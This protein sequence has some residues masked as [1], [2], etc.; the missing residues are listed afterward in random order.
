MWMSKGADRDRVDVL[1][2]FEH[3][4][5]GGPAIRAE[6]KRRSFAGIS[7][8]NERLRFAVTLRRE[9]RACAPKTL[10]VRRWQA[11]Q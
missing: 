3:V 2:I 7:D 8:P 11:R 4:V 1:L 5:H 10:P 9:K 6:V